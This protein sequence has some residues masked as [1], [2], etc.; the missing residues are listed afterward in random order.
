MLKSASGPAVNLPAGST[1][2]VSDAFG[3]ALVSAGAAREV[4]GLAAVA[5]ADAAPEPVTEVTEVAVEVAPEMATAPPQ[6]A[7]RHAPKHGKGRK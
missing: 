2:E 3:A 7:P 1:S 4:G 6:S 5:V